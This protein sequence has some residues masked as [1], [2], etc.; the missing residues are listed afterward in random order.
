MIAAGHRQAAPGGKDGAGAASVPIW[1]PRGRKGLDPRRPGEMLRR[2]ERFRRL[3]ELLPEARTCGAVHIFDLSGLPARFG[4]DWPHLGEKAW[5]IVE[6]ALDRELGRE[7]LYVAVDPGTIYA[8]TSGPNW[9]DA[10]RAMKLAAAAMTE[11]LCGLVAGG[12]SVRVRTLPFDL[13]VGLAGLSGLRELR[14]RIEAFG[15]R[16]EGEERRAFAQ[17]EKSLEVRYSPLVGLRRLLVLGHRLHVGRPGE[18]GGF[19]EAGELCPERALGVFDAA[20]DAWLA[21]ALAPLAAAHRQLRRGFTVLPVHYETLA[22]RHLREPLVAALR[23]LPATLRGHLI[24]HVVDL[25][26]AIP[27]GTL[28]RLSALIGPFVGALAGTVPLSRPDPERFDGTRVRVLAVPAREL[29]DRPSDVALRQL[30]RLLEAARR[31]RRRRVWVTE[32]ADQGG[33]ELCREAGVDAVC[34]PVF[35]PPLATP[36]SR[37]SLRPARRAQAGG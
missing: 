33:F 20:A 16:V 37:R 25:P 32:V 10:E 17:I 11:R 19:V 12:A 36:L 35:G 2:L 7:D 31:G 26:P 22:T 3:H 4:P 15:Q 8:F 6:H 1:P 34:G 29:A 21:R 28:A 23:V 18:D 24:L 27:Q 30:V 9:R 14:E 5:Q 13:R